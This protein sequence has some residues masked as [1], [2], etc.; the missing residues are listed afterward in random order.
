MNYLQVEPASF[1]WRVLRLNVPYLLS[2]NW[3]IEYFRKKYI[4]IWILDIDNDI[5]VNCSWGD[6]RWQY[7]Q[8]K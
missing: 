4:Y 8:T 6:T 7:L 3:E 5:F 2:F 1:L